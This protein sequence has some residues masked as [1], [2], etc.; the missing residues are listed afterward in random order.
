MS[1]GYELK[2]FR[3]KNS[4]PE[5]IRNERFCNGIENCDYGED[6]GFGCRRVRKPL[7]PVY[8]GNELEDWK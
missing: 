5:Y 7:I 3:C 2:T 1:Y 6:E 8:F 4:Q